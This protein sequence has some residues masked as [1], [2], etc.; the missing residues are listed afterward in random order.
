MRHLYAS[1]Q[2]DWMLPDPQRRMTAGEGGGCEA[3]AV[4]KDARNASQKQ[5]QRCSEPLFLGLDCSTQSMTAL[6]TNA[7]GRVVWESSFRFDER[8]PRYGTVNGVHRSSEHPDCV[9]IPSMMFVDALDAILANLRRC[10]AF[11]MAKI[12]AISGS[13]QQHASV[14]WAKGFDLRAA[15]ADGDASRPLVEVLQA[16]NAKVFHLDQ[17]PSWMDNSTSS[18]CRR[19]NQDAGGAQRVADISGSRAYERFTGNQI[20]KR[21]HDQPDFLDHVSRIALVSSMLT[22]L[23]VGEF[24]AIDDSD[25]SGMNLL[26]LR[27]REW[28]P[29]LLQSTA[30][31][32]TTPNA[33]EA[34]QKAL[35]DCVSRAYD[36]AGSVHP[37]FQTKYGFVPE[38]KIIAF[39]GDNPC[40]LAGIGLSQAGDVAVSLGTSSTVMAVVPTAQARASGEEG[41]YFCNPIDPDSLMVRARSTLKPT[42]RIV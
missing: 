4:D 5:Q 9:L 37:Y 20:A 34:L 31:E 3:T 40:S 18:F 30:Q 12:V 41:H 28:S 24:T 35:G 38:C 33:E 21:I 10:D 13:A 42:D 16:K 11:S 7:H 39:S 27:S 8:L 2:S 36:I 14:Y 1:N 17:G 15:M 29:E 22:S 26:D 19:L 25:G 32:S 23:L 6:V